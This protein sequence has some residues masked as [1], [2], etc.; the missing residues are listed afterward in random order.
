M[1]IFRVMMRYPKRQKILYVFKAFTEI[2]FRL[3]KNVF[4]YELEGMSDLKL[5]RPY[6]VF[7]KKERHLL[8]RVLD[9]MLGALFCSVLV[10]CQKQDNMQELEI[11]A[12]EAFQLL[13]TDYKSKEVIDILFSGFQLEN[14]EA[15]KGI[16]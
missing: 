1:D 10:S 15:E 3:K 11:N 2:P 12:T 8:V 4:Y 16:L 9:I 13:D 7:Q 14:S 5:D 6:G